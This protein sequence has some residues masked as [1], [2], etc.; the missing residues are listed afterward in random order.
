MNTGERIRYWRKEKGLTQQELADRLGCS[1]ANISQYEAGKRNAK[2]DTLY[3]ISE[4]LNVPYS[5]FIPRVIIEDDRV[6]LPVFDGVYEGSR[7]SAAQYIQAASF[8]EFALFL[9]S[10]GINVDLDN[11]QIS[12]DGKIYNLNRQQLI[13]LPDMSI[14]QIKTLIRSLAMMNET[15]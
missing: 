8:R 2:I 15:K 13:S 1:A 7:E 12:F 3:K 9:G 5:A 14:E 10:K 6:V 11:S 4:A